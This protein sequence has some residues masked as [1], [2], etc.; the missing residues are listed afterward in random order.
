VNP[1]HLTFYTTDQKKTIR[2]T[3][4]RSRKTVKGGEVAICV[5]EVAARVVIGLKRIPYLQGR[6]G[7]GDL[8]AQRALMDCT[9]P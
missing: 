8:S 3:V 5:R 6:K 1:N 7:M 2:G 4:L 9:R